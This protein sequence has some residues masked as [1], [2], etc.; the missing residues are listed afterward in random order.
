MIHLE[1]L[2]SMPLIRSK[3][4]SPPNNLL[5]D[6]SRIIFEEPHAPQAH[7]SYDKLYID[8]NDIYIV[9]FISQMIA[10]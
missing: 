7:N 9:V 6:W 10:Q 4:D 2:N 5:N 3:A 8:F 1:P